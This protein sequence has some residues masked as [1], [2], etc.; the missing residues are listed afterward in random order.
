M[1]NAIVALDRDPVRRATFIER[2]RARIAPLPGLATHHL[3]GDGWA[4]VW[5]ANPTAPISTR[6]DGN[7][8]TFL[9]GDAISSS[10]HR[11]SAEDVRSSW[12]SDPETSWDGFH[13]AIDVQGPDRLVASVDIMGLLPCYHWCGGGTVLVGTSV[14]LFLAHPGFEGS[15]DPLGLIGIML[16]NGQVGGR[17]LWKDVRRLDVRKRLVVAEGKASEM[18]AFRLPETDMSLRGLPLEGH[19]ELLAE[20]MDDAIRRHC[21]PATPH[22]LMLS[23]GLDSRQLGGFLADGGIPTTALTFGLDSDIEMRC[24]RKVARSLGVQHRTAEIPATAFPDAAESLLRMEG[25]AAGFCNVLEWGMLP[26]LEGMPSRLVLGHVFDGVVGGIH[27]PWAFDPGTGRYDFETV[28]KRFNRWGFSVQGLRELLPPELHREIEGVVEMVRD[29]YQSSSGEPNLQSWH[30][31]LLTRQRFHV[32]SAVWPMSFRCWPVSPV[33]DRKLFTLAAS[34]PAGSIS[35]RRLQTELLLARHPSLAAISLDRNSFDS[36]PVRPTI[37]DRIRVGASNKLRRL[38]RRI[39][40]PGA[41]REERFYY[42]TYDF[43][44]PGWHRVRELA[45]GRRSAV[46]GILNREVVD[47]LLPPPHQRLRTQDGIIDSSNAKLLVGLAL[48]GARYGF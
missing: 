5:A 29:C 16:M 26:H 32:G 14:D 35:G 11:M 17:T 6:A 4:A 7:T 12:R 28:F 15:L 10:G 19:V 24:A 23:G 22:G 1:A 39:P 45:E 27:I 41:G 38:W 34:M 2:A 46:P 3:E 47:R 20:A 18:Q 43:D 48:S 13:L 36:L 44:G 42:R 40:L 30:F 9:W 31:D 37:A 8:A 33:F 21:P 25:L